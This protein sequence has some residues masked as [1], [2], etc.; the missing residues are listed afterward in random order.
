MH[1]IEEQDAS[2]QAT[3]TSMPLQ[4]PRH[5]PLAHILRANCVEGVHYGSVVILAADGETIFET[6]DVD[7]AF[8][9]NAALR[10]IQV[11]GL[12]RAGLRLE[13]EW[14]ALATAGHSGEDRHL[15]AVRNMLIGCGL[16]EA[17][18][19]NRPAMPCDPAVLTKWL[20]DGRPASRLAHHA[21]GI[22]AAMVMTAQAQDWPIDTYLDRD[23]PVQRSIRET[24]EELTDAPVA[25]TMT[26]G[27]AAPAFSVSLRG[28]TRALARVASADPETGEGQVG[29]AIREHPEMAA[30][31]WRDVARLMRAV[32]GLL[33]K[34]GFEGVQVTVLPDGRAIGV[35]IADG[36]DRARMPV[37]AAGLLLCGVGRGILT[38]FLTS[39]VWDGVAVVGQV[40]VADVFPSALPTLPGVV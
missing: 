13:G 26:D 17:D 36:A 10:P 16:T 2:E 19:G 8:S 15:D 23:H 30:G 18:L 35:K 11:V 34:D 37:S 9:P 25:R 40:R 27:C 22:H 24:V 29:K 5:V 32:P 4:T 1:T 12:L 21:S 3:Q 31:S 20:R 6:G 38:E 7:V 39:P 33:A 14:L 28:L